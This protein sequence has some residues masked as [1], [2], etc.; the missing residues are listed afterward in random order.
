[1]CDT[2][3]IGQRRPCRYY[4]AST[5]AMQM[6]GTHYSNQNAVVLQKQ[7]FLGQKIVRHKLQMARVLKGN[8]VSVYEASDWVKK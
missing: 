3:D 8:L 7:R 4:I 1:M 2:Y 5:I 6:Q